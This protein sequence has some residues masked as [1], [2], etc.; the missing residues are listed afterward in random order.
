[1]SGVFDL[2][3]TEADDL[4]GALKRGASKG[5]PIGTVLS[6]EGSGYEAAQKEILTRWIPDSIAMR[7]LDAE[8]EGRPA[9]GKLPRL[10][11]GKLRRLLVNSGFAVRLSSMRQW[12][13][14]AQHIFSFE[15]VEIRQPGG[16]EQRHLSLIGL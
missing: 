3:I 12:R 13:N 9:T 2:A 14:T 10:S 7:E 15:D 8:E 16:P 11:E 6:I 4:L 1:M 5:R